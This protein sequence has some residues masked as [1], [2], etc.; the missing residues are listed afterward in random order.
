MMK[1]RNRYLEKINQLSSTGRKLLNLPARLMTPPQKKPAL[2]PG[3]LIYVGKERTDPARVSLISYDEE[4]FAE[5]EISD[6]QECLETRNRQKT[7]WI[8]VDGVHQIDLIEKIGTHFGIHPLVLEDVVQTNQRP[9]LEE[10]S[11]YLYLIVKM[12]YFRG[13]ETTLQC[14]Q[15]SLLLGKSFMISFQEHRGDVFD[16]VRQRIKNGNGRI[17]KCGA[18][19]L[20]YALIDAIVDHYFVVI[21]QL[22]DRLDRLEEQVNLNADPS[23]LSEVHRMKREV[24]FMRKSVWPLREVVNTLHKN[25]FSLVR[26]E[27]KLYLKDVYDHTIQVVETIETHYDMISGLQD[28]YLSMVSNRMN[29]VMKVLTVIATVFIPP[30]FLAGVYGMNFD[31]MPELHTAWGYFVVLCVMGLSILGMLFYFRKKKWL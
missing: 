23:V 18:D 3:T 19:Y 17:R 12:F 2:P 26:D 21:E 14:E 13:G 20:V 28:L 31:H 11:G 7:T 22:G 6:I 27:T 5:K 30:T 25:D 24:I 16:S 8:N 10:H 4:N 29:E 9:K 15:I 1:I